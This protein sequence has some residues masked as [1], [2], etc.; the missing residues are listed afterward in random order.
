MCG[1]GEPKEARA[2]YNGNMDGNKNNT[3][4]SNSKLA[5]AS[6]ICGLI[7]IFIFPLAFGGA[8]IIFGIMVKDRVE[9]D[10]RDYQNARLGIVFGIIGI[11]FWVITLMTMNYLNFDLN[12]LMGNGQPQSAI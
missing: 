8:A 11:V 5:L 10:S 12:S 6:F 7:S 9:R 1:T 2:C 3:N 4:S